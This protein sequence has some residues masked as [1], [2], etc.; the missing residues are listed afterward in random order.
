M[1]LFYADLAE[2]QEFTTPARTIT[3][4]DVVQFS[5][6]T[7]DYNPI[8][9]DAE[10]AADTRYRQRIVHGLF[11]VSVCI[12]LMSRTGIFEV[13]VALLGVDEWRPCTD[14]HRRYRALPYS[15]PR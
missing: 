5:G 13:V 3:E 7:G 11:G 2:G 1:A 4:S 14:I 15:H 10:F 6:L 9:T 8:H 12:G